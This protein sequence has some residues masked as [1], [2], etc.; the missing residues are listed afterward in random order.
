MISPSLKKTV[1]GR[2]LSSNVIG[3]VHGTRS[4]FLLEAND[5]RISLISDL[6]KLLPGGEHCVR[7]NFFIWRSACATQQGVG[8]DWVTDRAFRSIMCPGSKAGV[9]RLWNVCFGWLSFRGDYVTW[10]DG[11]KEK[12][13][14][15]QGARRSHRASM[16]AGWG[17]WDRNT[18][19]SRKEAVMPETS[20]TL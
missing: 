16:E 10:R 11:P 12:T 1:R 13:P 18:S 17:A 7:L 4:L 19:G 9:G 20:Q 14:W 3:L 15:P 6:E 2:Y 5:L 8:G